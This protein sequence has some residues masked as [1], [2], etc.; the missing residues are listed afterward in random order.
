MPEGKNEMTSAGRNK[1]IKDF[2]L[3][4]KQR[5][6]PDGIFN[7]CR[8]CGTIFVQ[9]NFEENLFICKECGFYHPMPARKRIENLADPGTFEELYGELASAD[10]LGFKAI[11]AYTDRIA[12]ETAKNDINEAIITGRCEIGGNPTYLG[13]MEQRFLMASMGSVVG[14]KVTRLFEDALRDRL[15]VVIVSASGGARMH[16]GLISLM[17]M[18]KTSAAVARFS[19]AGLLY[20]SVLTNPTMAGVMASYASLG[21]IIIAEPR[22]LIGF[23]GPRVIRET[24]RIELPKGFQE[25]E[26]LLEHGQID[27]IVERKALRSTLARLLDYG[28][29]AY[30]S[31]R[32]SAKGGTSA[33]KEG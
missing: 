33:R 5:Q 23:T 30:P 19:Q 26:F 27:M 20:I 24:L 4:P 9:K 1:R 10:P 31:N 29:N 7:K 32:H 6:I 16:E 12:R 14:E 3:K 13:V 18:A 28:C 11:E 17:Q 15:P 21:D 2:P 25:S 8:K 22:A